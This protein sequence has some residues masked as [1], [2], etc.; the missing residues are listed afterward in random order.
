M[1]RQCQPVTSTAIPMTNKEV[2]RE[3]ANENFVTC[4]ALRYFSSQT[5]LGAYRR[6]ERHER[7]DAGIDPL[8]SIGG[9]RR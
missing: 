3:H 5:S 7:K 2:A 8:V 9:K 1:F 6:G 4:S